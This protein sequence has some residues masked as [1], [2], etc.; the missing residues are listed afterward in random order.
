MDDWGIELSDFFA[1]FARICLHSRT[2][3]QAFGL[4]AHWASGSK[5]VRALQIFLHAQPI[6]V[7]AL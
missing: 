6:F 2:W 5:N 1:N 3:Y 7:Q 4:H